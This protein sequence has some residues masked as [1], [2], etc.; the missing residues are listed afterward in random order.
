LI[1]AVDSPGT[2]YNT[3]KREKIFEQGLQIKV[4]AQFLRKQE[5]KSK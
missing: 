5:E 2:I 3:E 4:K 1:A